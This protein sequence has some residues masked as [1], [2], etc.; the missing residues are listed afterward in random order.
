MEQV[1]KNVQKKI[2][3]ILICRYTFIKYFTGKLRLSCSVRYIDSPILFFD[4]DFRVLMCTLWYRESVTLTAFFT[5]RSRVL[6]N[7]YFPGTTY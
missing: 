6:Q 3:V 4:D 5:E 2:E 1:D 7:A